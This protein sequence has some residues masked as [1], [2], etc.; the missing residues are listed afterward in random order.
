MDPSAGSLVAKLFFRKRWRPLPSMSFVG[1]SSSR[2]PTLKTKNEGRNCPPRNPSPP[3]KARVAALLIK[4][5]MA[6]PFGCPEGL[7]MMVY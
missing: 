7:F 2:D 3:R 6:Q 1:T 5:P 4:N